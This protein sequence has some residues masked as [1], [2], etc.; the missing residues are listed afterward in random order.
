[1]R[2]IEWRPGAAVARSWRRFRRRPTVMQVRTAAVV[3]AVFAGTTAWVATAPAD[4]G[5]QSDAR[6]HMSTTTT[7]V[8]GTAATSVA[9]LF[10]EASTSTRGVTDRSITVV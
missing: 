2:P 5:G 1:M 7:V 9:N 4:R 8:H 10:P 6:P 3:V